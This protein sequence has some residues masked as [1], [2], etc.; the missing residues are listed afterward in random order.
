MVREGLKMAR[1]SSARTPPG[2]GGGHL[3]VALWIL[4]S[5]LLVAGGWILSW[6][7]Q[8]NAAGYALWLLAGAG[9]LAWW[10]SR[11]RAS[12]PWSRGWHGPRWRRRFRRPLAG[13]FLVLAALAIVGGLA[14]PPNMFDAMTYRVPRLLHWAAADQW[15]WIHSGSPRMNC[16]A[17][18]FE[19]MAMPLL[20]FT[21]SDRAIFLL[22]VVSFLLLPGLV[23]S[24]FTRLGVRGRVA[25][26]WMWLLPTGYSF[27]LQAG[28]SAN[29]MFAAPYALAAVGFALRA[30]CSRQCSDLWLSLLAAA[31]TTGAK[32]TNLPLLL[33]WLLAVAPSW[34]LTLSRPL[35]LLGTGAWAMLVSF[36]PTACLNM[37]HCGDWSGAVLEPA[38]PKAVPL[39]GVVGNALLLL[40]QN[41]TPPIFPWAS[42]WS[43]H[44]PLFLPDHWRSLMNGSFQQGWWITAEIPV[45]DMAAPG[46]GLAVLTSLSLLW[47]GWRRLRHGP[48]GPGAGKPDAR[49]LF[50]PALVAWSAWASLLVYMMKAGLPTP[51]RILTPYVPLLLAPLLL[52]SWHEQLVRR[53]WWRTTALVVGALAAF[54][55]IA[56]PA[57]P[58]WPA[59]QLL[60][61]WQEQW[62]GVGLLQRAQ[63][64]FAV[65]DQR[66]DA[67]KPVRDL[68]P[69]GTSVVG[70][71]LSSDDPETSLWRPFGTRRIVHVLPN[72]PP[73]VPRQRGVAFVLLSSRL[74]EATG[75]TL[76]GWL[77]RFN[78]EVVAQTN[79]SLYASQPAGP[80]F[81]ARL[82]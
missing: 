55:V 77:R 18:G 52:C 24:V 22:N 12:P 62:P 53:C 8:L 5:A 47:V 44:F 72:D 68:V 13:A 67:L 38:V 15:H 19:W 63:R 2:L 30:R 61:R 50:G 23:F 27:L 4:L 76:E 60:S 20:I 40:V 75:L 36:L 37:K 26:S 16:R 48:A 6:L 25:W 69:P 78:A 59:G 14:H 17:A 33:P 81:V 51:G 31:L 58:L 66:H 80:W 70:A 11:R 21:H 9:A 49:V 39:V 74:T 79:L 46:F 71:V 28:G 57:R 42:W 29:D 10:W 56:N 3:W 65:Y 73:E 64:V 32:A 54:V 82:R 45:E 1:D 43:K 7:R 41:F 34:R 35:C